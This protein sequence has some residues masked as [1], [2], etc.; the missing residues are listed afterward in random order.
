MTL[1]RS[2]VLFADF[3]FSKY[4]FLYAVQ[5]TREKNGRSIQ[6]FQMWLILESAMTSMILLAREPSK[7]ILRSNRS[8]LMRDIDFHFSSISHLLDFLI[9]VVFF[10]FLLCVS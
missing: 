5:N 9:L 2:F 6:P 10:C 1:A 4:N 7:K 3:M 8:S